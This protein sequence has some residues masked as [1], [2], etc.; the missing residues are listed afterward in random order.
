LL[1]AETGETGFVLR[2]EFSI[3]GGEEENL[4]V[5]SFLQDTNNLCKLSLLKE[6]DVVKGQENVGRIQ[7]GNR[8]TGQD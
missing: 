2:E 7:R 8:T 6:V 5:K 4:T 3:M 1:S